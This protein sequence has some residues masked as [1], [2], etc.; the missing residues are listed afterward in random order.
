MQRP[1][2]MTVSR[3]SA[4]SLTWRAASN[5]C[6]ATVVSSGD[7]SQ[8]WVDLGLAAATV[9]LEVS[10]SSNAEL[11]EH[12]LQFRRH[13][14]QTGILHAMGTGVSRRVDGLPDRTVPTV[15]LRQPVFSS[16]RENAGAVEIMM[17]PKESDFS[18]FCVSCPLTLR[19]ITGAYTRPAIFE[20][21]LP[22]AQVPHPKAIRYQSSGCELLR[23][24]RSIRPVSTASPWYRGSAYSG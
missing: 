3:I 23:Q 15:E 10:G 1:T 21:A 22:I 24:P 19:T 13:R 12:G 9:F 6:V 11:S 17:I 20:N 7:S 5:P 8:R 4:Q 18:V 2:K 16:P 14:V